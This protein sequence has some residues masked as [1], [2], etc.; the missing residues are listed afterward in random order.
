MTNSLAQGSP[1]DAL[2][3]L[4]FI[5]SD[6]R[7]TWISV[8]MALKTEY[9]DCGIQLFDEWSSKSA[10]YS[11][12]S[13][14]AVWKSFKGQGVTM[15]TVVHLAE[16]NGFRPPVNTQQP[17]VA[18]RSTVNKPSSTS[19]YAKKLWLA[20]SRA[21]NLV[22]SHAYAV[23]K[24]IG[25]A[26]RAARGNA[27][28]SVIGQSNDCIVVPI[29]N[30]KTGLVQGV[31]CINTDGVKQ[32]FGQVSGGALLLGNTRIKNQTWY[33]CEGWASAFSTVFHLGA[34]AAACA[35]GKG[36]LKKTAELIA[37]VYEPDEIIILREVD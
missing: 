18:S 29:R 3:L 2:V 22:A 30:I 28:G 6:D 12:R 10:N 26:G 35:F 20:S 17:S 23:R 15:G 24:G 32:S 16:Q 27:S 36:Q 21:G 5:P 33:V 34:K 1:L 31:Q 9:G 25:G 4:R 11:P 19:L 13:V 14:K 8:G 37:E 7:E